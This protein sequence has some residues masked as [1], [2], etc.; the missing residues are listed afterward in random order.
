MRKKVLDALN[1][2]QTDNAKIFAESVIRQKKEAQNT[3]R[4]AA[5]MGAL[6][7]KVESAARTQQVSE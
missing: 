1:K 2:G 7:M 6:A 3:R 4:F 5:K